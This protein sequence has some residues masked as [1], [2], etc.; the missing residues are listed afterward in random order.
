MSVRISGH[1]AVAALV[2]GVL[3]LDL[4]DASFA[5]WSAAHPF[6]TAAATGL[7]VLLVTVLIVDRVVAMRKE[8]DQARAISAQAT[9][10]MAQ[11]TRASHAVAL[12]LDGSGPREDA[13][14]EVR[15]YLTM[16]SVGTTVLLD[17]HLSRPF[18]E[19]AQALG[20]EMSAALARPEPSPQTRERL[21]DAVARMRSESTPLLR[22]LDP[23]HELDLGWIRLRTGPRSDA[24]P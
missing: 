3:V 19:A 12:V 24:G 20:A 16:V 9:F 11:A 15:T 8:R 1:W 4:S 21:D 14:E 18:L 10:V 13:S 17:A 6:F 5:H 23:G 7:L 2:A 22:I